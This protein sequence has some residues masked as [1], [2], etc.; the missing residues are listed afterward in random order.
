M[1]YVRWLQF[2]CVKCGKSRRSNTSVM[3]NKV[4]CCK[5]CEEGLGETICLT[6]ALKNYDL[7]DYML[8]PSRTAG[9]HAQ[10]I[11]LPLII[12][13]TKKCGT[14]VGLGKCISYRFY[15]KDVERIAHLVHENLEAHMAKKK[16][17]R[18]VRKYKKALPALLR[19]KIQHLRV[20]RSHEHK[21]KWWY[22]DRIEHFEGIQA[23]SISALDI[24]DVMKDINI[25][26]LDEYWGENHETVCVE[27]NCERCASDKAERWQ[28]DKDAKDAMRMYRRWY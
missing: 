14:A 19:M 5:E 10:T 3:L 18:L 7:Q 27:L 12:Y 22:T 11:D 2:D 21:R 17:A 1:E 9:P 20:G 23:Q 6:D 16:Q 15:L 28:I 8:L 13:G 24:D 26:H 4:E 25:G